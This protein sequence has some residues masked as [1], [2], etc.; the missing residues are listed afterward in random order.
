MTVN[1]RKIIHRRTEYARKCTTIHRVYL[2]SGEFLLGCVERAY[3]TDTF[4][5]VM[6]V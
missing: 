4:W 6:H 3:Q 1:K 2:V 5:H